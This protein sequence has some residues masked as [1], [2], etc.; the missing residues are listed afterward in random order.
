[1]M[2]FH[3]LLAV[4][5]EVEDSLPDGVEFVRAQGPSGCKSFAEAI[6]G[7]LAMCGVSVDALVQAG[8]FK[9][10]QYP[11]PHLELRL[12]NKKSGEEFRWTKIEVSGKETPELLKQIIL[13]EAR[14]LA[15]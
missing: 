8:V 1:M 13:F 9:P 3:E 7:P 11:S 5:D 2:T 4:I 6:T 14:N 10:W 15:E 12:R